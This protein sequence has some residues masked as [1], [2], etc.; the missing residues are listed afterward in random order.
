MGKVS[1]RLPS[2]SRCRELQLLLQ[3]LGGSLPFLPPSPPLR[4]CP[5]I[6]SRI[7][8]WVGSSDEQWVRTSPCLQGAMGMEDQI[9]TGRC[10]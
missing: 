6:V 1:I 10:G 3:T 7:Q 2:V 8:L 4:T 5:S 9:V